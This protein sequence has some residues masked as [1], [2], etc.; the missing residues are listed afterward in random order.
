M[1]RHLTHWTW[2]VGYSLTERH[3]PPH[4]MRSSHSLLLHDRLA[5]YDPLKPQRMIG[6]GK[7]RKVTLDAS[8]SGI[9]SSLRCR[10]R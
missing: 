10:L 6:W 1:R 9:E 4:F 5:P 8:E 3:L 2:K 7:E